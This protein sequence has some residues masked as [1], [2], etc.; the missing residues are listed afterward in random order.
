M[1]PGRG[2]TGLRAEHAGRAWAVLATV[3]ALAVIVACGAWFYVDQRA[4]VREDVARDMVGIARLKVDQVDAWRRDRQTL[5]AALSSRRHLALWLAEPTAE[6][7]DGILDRL[8][9]SR[10]IVGAVDVALFD[11]DGGPLLA[12]GGSGPPGRETFDAVERALASGAPALGELHVDAAGGTPRLDV[13][14]PVVTPDGA[15]VGALVLTFDVSGDLFPLVAS[16]PRPSA[17]AEAYLVRRDGSDVLYVSDLRHATGAALVL[18]T[19]LGDVESPA[20]RALGGELGFREGTDYRGQRVASAA[21]AVPGSDW[22]LMAE[23]DDAEAFAGWRVRARLLVALS[24]AAVMV[25]ALAGYGWRQ[26]DLRRAAES[27][28][29]T[30]RSL[31]DAHA[32]LDGLVDHANGP[33]VVWDPDLR[34]TR[35]NRA[36]ERLTGRHARDVVGGPLEV[37]FPPDRVATTLAL[38]NH[39][40]T[41]ERWDTT[42]IAV[43]R[44]DGS[45]ATVLWNSATLFRDDGV[46]PIATI[47]QGLD[48]TEQMRSRVELEASQRRADALLALPGAS[49]RLGESEFRAFAAALTEELLGGVS[50]L[51]YY[52]DEEAGDVVLVD[53]TPLATAAGCRGEVGVRH[54][55]P[56]AGVWA[57]VLRTKQVLTVED[58]AA[59]SDDRRWPGGACPQRRLVLAPWVEDGRVV[60]AGLFF[61]KPEPFTE[62]D[63]QTILLMG[64]EV[65]R[66]DR[67]RRA[68]ERQRT[69]EARLRSVVDASPVATALASP[70]GRIVYVNASCERAFGYTLADIPT[71]EAW[72]RVAY[73]DPTY[74]ASVFAAWDARLAAASA[75]GGPSEPLEACVRC[76]DGSERTVWI[77]AAEAGD[78]ARGLLVVTLLDITEL[79]R[80]TD[81]AEHARELMGGVIEHNTSAVAVHDRDLRYVYVS[82]RYLDAFR[83]ADRDV[84]GRRPD[85]VSRDLGARWRDVHRRALEGE[86]PSADRDRLVHGDGAVDWLRWSCRPWFERGGSVGG[87]IHYAEVITDR[88]GS[89]VTLRASE[90]RFRAVSDIASDMVYSWRRSDG[91][92]WRFEWI[93]GDAA[94]VFD[95]DREALM[96]LGDW[97]GFVHED[98]RATYDEALRGLAPGASSDVV[99][100]VRDRRGRVRFVRSI[101]R[102]EDGRDGIDGVVG[103]VLFGSLTDVSE[104]HGALSALDAF[105]EQGVNLHLIERLDSTIVRANHAWES[106]VGYPPSELQ[107][108]RALDFVHPDDVAT[109]IEAMGSLGAGS[110]AQGF[111]NRCRA[112]DGSYRLLR[113]SAV[114]DMERGLVFA[115]ATDV[116]ERRATEDALAD[117]ERRLKDAQ[118]MAQMGSWELDL[119][120]DEL[121]WTDEVYRVFEVDPV[122]ER[123]TV[124]AFRSRVHPADLEFVDRSFDHAVTEGRPLDVTHRLLMPDG[125]VKHVHAKGAVAR[126]H[127]G[128][129]SRVFGT[130]QD[131]TER[132]VADDRLRKLAMAVEQS[133]EIVM[134]T[135]VDGRIEYVNAAFVA[136][137]GY[138][139]EE[140]L[141]EN[142]R[143]LQSGKTP[144]STFREMWDTLTAGRP[145]RGEF[146]NR[147]RDGSECVEAA[148][149]VPVRQPDG[150]VTHYVAVK[151]DITE[152]RRTE[153]ELAE[154]RQGLEVM[155][156]Q[157]TAQL[158]EALQRAEAA[159]TAKSTF[160]ANMSHEIRT[161]LNAILGLAHLLRAQAGP[162]QLE[163][164]SKIDAAGRHLLSI[165]N[166][167]LD[168]S[169]IEAGRMRIE[170]QDFHLAS[171]MDQVRSMIA[172]AA[173]AK[174]LVV[175]VDGDHVPLW[176]RGDPT[177]LRQALLNYAVNAVKFTERGRVVL[178]AQLVGEPTGE[179][180]V[181]FE[182]QDTGIGIESEKLP[183]LFR[184]F[185]QADA[186]TTRKYGG[187]GLGLVITRR[188]AEMMGGEAGGES[189]PQV[190]STFWFT[191]RLRRG[192]GILPATEA[193]V[194]PTDPDAALRAR[195]RGRRVLLAEDNAINREVALELLHAV[196]LDVEV[197][198]DGVEAL[199][200]AHRGRFDLALMD[201]QMPNLDGLAATRALRALPGWAEVPILAMTAN[202]FE[203]DRR[204]CLA[205]GMDDVVAK[206]VEPAWLYA[207]LLKWLSGEARRG[208]IAPRPEP[209]PPE[210]SVGG[211][212][213]GSDADRD[214]ADATPGVWTARSWGVLRRDTAFDRRLLSLFAAHHV[215][216]PAE[217]RRAAERGDDGAAV[218]IAHALRGAAGNVGAGDLQERAAAL[219]VAAR[220]AAPS[221]PVLASRMADDL[222]ALLEGLGDD[223]EGSSGEG[224]EAAPGA[225]RAVV[226]RLTGLLRADDPTA[227][228]LVDREAAELRAA[229]GRD[230]SGEVRRR[231]A[232]YDFP[233]ALALVLDHAGEG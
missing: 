99:L 3:S 69:E 190:G 63:R 192:R 118:R 58:W 204:A 53:A 211:G 113:W 48:I 110:V 106:V 7:T 208:P 85:E 166:D 140:V 82:Q 21:V 74:R 84:I 105:F 216:D 9:E 214:R 98:D 54:P 94:A 83:V 209:N 13:A 72:G 68:A 165:I 125:R 189:V 126:D 223:L 137:T 60:A 8:H 87:I 147:R 56:D 5:V 64:S 128:R 41:G 91:G 181:R 153:E 168:V 150:R 114:T 136:N 210:A 1:V 29:R 198:E 57:H 95:D 111:E 127:V 97:S 162:A 17:T 47:A 144:P 167:I 18:R 36:F 164:L 88:V 108:R 199:M 34:I 11:R 75:S 178:R 145:W 101:A 25:A 226:A 159:N 37:L 61:D 203:E 93:A 221:W 200:C 139:A 195:Y 135:D 24:C 220:A 40:A 16:W 96:A 179:F 55:L 228:D 73:P 158:D 233:G 183:G 215:G 78:A 15:T 121:T 19:P 188:L 20:A 146:V 38:V 71:F 142:P 123:A 45:E 201:V 176:L 148:N 23:I 35:F 130:V 46:T 50:G 173:A 152:R 76:R 202:A 141:G 154:Y 51:V 222:A 156:A 43:A 186:S 52:V 120:S 14:A 117:S 151:E 104:V 206:P 109:T 124:D 107:G 4:R 131:V 42:E 232:A 10:A 30:Q 193:A 217:L 119:V 155:V 230:R 180:L 31:R 90:A 12:L 187:S 219:E 185:E 194:G 224:P 163:R 100:R 207:V 132:W 49:E 170:E 67:L 231:V 65:W 28:L 177:R 59:S 112:A 33:I 196:G 92:A 182:V 103:P 66:L 229:L 133:Q 171:V 77:V 79:R 6:A 115:A 218:R 39:T 80:A 134:I 212:G 205:A 2:G 122:S 27:L 89:E 213:A 129:P 81:E 22:V 172:D 86:V 143:I 169:K 184:A 116:T 149:V 62:W 191:A 161:P 227:L 102:V 32:Y 138:L 174:G 157:R 44:V 175:E 225:A 197:A 70:D 160:L 26:R